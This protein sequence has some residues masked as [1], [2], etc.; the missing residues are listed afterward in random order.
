MLDLVKTRRQS[1][2]DDPA[3]DE[4]LEVLAIKLGGYALDARAVA[5]GMRSVAAI[6]V[7]L[8]QRSALSIQEMST[9]RSSSDDK[10]VSANRGM[11]GIDASMRLA[12]LTAGF[13][14]W[15]P[16]PSRQRSGLHGIAAHGLT[17]C[18]SPR[19][20]RLRER[21]SDAALPE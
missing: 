5:S 3:M 14:L 10:C 12:M 17:A 11:L 6:P 8:H 1:G 16:V 2:E 13:R 19:L 7:A 9:C 4:A 21:V 18:V 20:C 15:Y